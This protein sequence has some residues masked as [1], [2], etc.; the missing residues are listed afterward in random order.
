MSILQPK[1]LCTIWALFRSILSRAIFKG[2]NE[3]LKRQRTCSRWWL[4]WQHSMRF[5]HL[6]KGTC[7]VNVRM[8]CYIGIVAFPLSNLPMAPKCSTPQHDMD[9]L[10]FSKRQRS[11]L[12]CPA[13]SFE[14]N[15]SVPWLFVAYQAIVVF[16]EVRS[17]DRDTNFL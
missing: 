17:Y 4:S 12:Y 1:F 10:Q 6:A 2:L 3:N 13:S 7:S 15:R 14:T 9:G 8:E 16:D 5:F 11:W